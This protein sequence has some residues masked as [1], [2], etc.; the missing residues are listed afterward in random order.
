[1]WTYVQLDVQFGVQMFNWTDGPT[2]DLTNT[3]TEKVPTKRKAQPSSSRKN[4]KQCK[5]EN[6]TEIID[7]ENFNFE[8]EERKLAFKK[9]ELQI[10]AQEAAAKLIK[11]IIKK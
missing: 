4:S 10:K 5:I 7:V 8:L 1:L 9:R 2:L 3:K 11:T 6:N